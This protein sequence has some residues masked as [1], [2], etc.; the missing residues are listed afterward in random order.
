MSPDCSDRLIEVGVIGRPHGV[1][2][3]VR[4]FLYNSTS[5]ILDLF[6]TITLQHK[7][8]HRDYVIENARPTNAGY[9]IAFQGVHSKDEALMLNGAKILL[10]REA[11]PPPDPDEFYVAD[12]IGLEVW[13]EGEL[14][15]EIFSSREQGGIE[16]INVRSRG[17]ELEIPVVEQYIADIQIGNGRILVRDTN[18]LPRVRRRERGKS[19]ER[20]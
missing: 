12:L 13:Q 16:V 1:R 2:G 8:G 18:E 6:S 10:P 14:L 5:D 17:V 20:V 4:V 7:N 19:D 9:L 3:E 15:G 11:L